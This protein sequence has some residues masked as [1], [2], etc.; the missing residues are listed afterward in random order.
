MR[1][2]RILFAPDDDWYKDFG[3]SKLG[4]SNGYPKTVLTKGMAAF[5]KRVEQV[6][7][8]CGRGCLRTGRGESAAW[9]R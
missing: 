6:K 1:P 9:S 3:S 5:G 8:E 4:G 7:K 2:G